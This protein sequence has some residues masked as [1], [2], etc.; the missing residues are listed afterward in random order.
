MK[1]GKEGMQ[2]FA[3]ALIPILWTYGGWH[4]NTFMGGETKDPSR[5][6]PKALILALALITFLYLA[7]NAVYLYLIPLAEMAESGLVISDVMAALFGASGGKIVDGLV[8]LTSLGTMNGVLM[9]GSRMAQACFGDFR[10]FSSS[11][12]LYFAVCFMGVLAVLM[13]VL[14]TFRS[15]LFFTGIFVWLFFAFVSV[16]VFILRRQGN[17]AKPSRLFLHPLAPALFFFLSAALF[18]NTLATYPAQ[19]L[20]GFGLV[21]PAI[22]LYLT[23]RRWKQSPG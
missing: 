11:A 15:L 1:P 3:L 7:I 16:S 22:P 9:T 14:G 23:A 4:E 5:V 12:V 10:D 20:I 2:H 17:F 13:M 18:F 21:L 19:S 6:I 8:I